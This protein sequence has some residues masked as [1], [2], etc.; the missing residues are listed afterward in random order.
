MKPSRVYVTCVCDWTAAETGDE[1]KELVVV[2]KLVT[3]LLQFVNDEVHEQQNWRKTLHV[4]SRLD[5]RP[6][7]H[8]THPVLVE[9]RVCLFVCLSVCLSVRLS[10]VKHD[11]MTRFMSSRTGVKLCRSTHGLTNDLLNT[12]IIQC[13]SN[14]GSVCLSVCLY[15]CSRRSVS[16]TLSSVC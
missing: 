15:V 8:S 1:Y 16:A 7:E 13:L 11:N 5:K 12:P 2:R 14:Y 4:Y 3:D 6:I 9:L 10:V